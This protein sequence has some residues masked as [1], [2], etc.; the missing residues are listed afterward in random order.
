MISAKYM[1]QKIRYSPFQ[2]LIFTIFIA[3]LNLWMW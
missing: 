3:H 1:S 2:Y